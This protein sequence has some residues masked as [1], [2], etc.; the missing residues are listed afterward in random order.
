MENDTEED[1]KA[2]LF[3]ALVAAG[4]LFSGSLIK[5]FASL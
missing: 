2:K 1:S 5:I 3:I 4:I